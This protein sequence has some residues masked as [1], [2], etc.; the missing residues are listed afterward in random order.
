LKLECCYTRLRKQ[1]IELRRP[2]GKRSVKLEHGVI[3]DLRPL[4]QNLLVV[5]MVETKTFE[6][7]SRQLGPI[8]RAGRREAHGSGVERSREDHKCRRLLGGSAQPKAKDGRKD[9]QESH[10]GCK[11]I[12]LSW[13]AV[14]GIRYGSTHLSP[15]GQKR[16]R[17]VSYKARTLV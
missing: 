12:A 4:P 14:P 1:V 6:V 7:L 17:D 8:D 9:F 13:G 11:Y 16:V 5:W 15:Y 3:C 10:R 2:G